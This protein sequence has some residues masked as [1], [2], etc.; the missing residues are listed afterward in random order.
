MLRQLGLIHER[1]LSALNGPAAAMMC[2]AA[3]RSS[4]QKLRRTSERCSTDASFPL[5]VRSAHSETQAQ[6][7]RQ[8]FV[9]VSALMTDIIDASGRTT[10]DN[11]E[12]GGLGISNR[13]LLRLNARGLR[14]NN[15]LAGIAPRLSGRDGR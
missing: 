9:I 8:L 6:L 1:R 13:F 5:S 12:Q 3:S 10:S 4:D 14:S 11:L 15:A 2:A 7:P